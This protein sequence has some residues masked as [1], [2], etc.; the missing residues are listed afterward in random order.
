MGEL[1][2]EQRAKL[3]QHEV[4]MSKVAEQADLFKEH[5]AV[6]CVLGTNREAAKTAENFK[7]V[8]LHMVKDSAAAAKEAG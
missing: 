7:K 8:D 3:T 4:D 6:F 1:T 2:D 5:H